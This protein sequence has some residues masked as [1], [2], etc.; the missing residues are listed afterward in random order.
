MFI[1]FRTVIV[2]KGCISFKYSGSPPGC[3]FESLGELLK[4]RSMPGPY[5]KAMK[6]QFLGVGLD[7][8][9]FL[10]SLSNSNVHLQFRVICLK[11]KLCM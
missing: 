11:L 10:S 3:I 9:I 6:S 7:I 8:G 4:K 2:P 5:V 1:N